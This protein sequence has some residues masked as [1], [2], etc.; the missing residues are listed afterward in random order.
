MAN[1][2][3]VCD[4]NFR[5][6]EIK[7]VYRMPIDQ[8]ASS[9]VPDRI[10]IKEKLTRQL[11]RSVMAQFSSLPE[12]LL[13][14]VDNAF[15][16]F[17]GIHGGEHL[18]IDIIITKDVVIVENTGGKGM[19]AKQLDDWL[20]WGAPIKTDSIGEYGQGGKAAMGYLGSAW[21]VHA[22]RWDES[23][24]W[25]VKDNKWDDMSIKEKTYVANPTSETRYPGLGYCK[26]EIRKL[27]KHRQD[28]ARIKAVLSNIYRK[29]LEGDRVTMTFNGDPLSLLKL[30]LY[31]G[32][33]I[34]QFKE[35]TILGFYI[36]GWVGRLKRDARV[37]NES[38]ITGGMRVLR[39]ERLICDGEYFGHPDF[40]YKASLGTLIG[41]VEL[42][43]KVPVLPNKTGFDTDSQEWLA[44]RKILYKVLEPHIK[45][46]LS[47]R[48]EETVTREERKRIS[49]IREMLIDALKLLD[50]FQ[51][52]NKL[53]EEKGR[54]S[55][56][57][58]LEE[59]ETRNEKEKKDETTPKEPRTTPPKSA[60][61]TLRRLGRMPEWELRFL[62]P[63]IRSDW[64]EK[65]GHPCLLINKNFC[66]YKERKGD[67]LYI[68]ETAIL[69]LA[70]LAGDEKLSV[71][72]YLSEANML[73][74][75]FC[76][77]YDS[78]SN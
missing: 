14:L 26:F 5:I 75:A 2:G 56:E 45:E 47:Q 22:K 52:S 64:G 18:N 73:M 54:K 62:E 57:P 1:R 49:T 20:N 4:A 65:G 11:L 40:R 13:E 25:E 15:D 9:S 78:A 59:A 77:V 48:E 32:F 38:K 37:K 21:V 29:F 70:K 39:K 66:Q 12:A 46:L 33:Q 58:K 43:A 51:I 28:I 23:I 55:P 74:R 34:Q 50:K 69:E 41:E 68:A 42:P 7:E 60:V 36:S 61:G 8:I 35:K 19:G 30:P 10:L 63:D 53:N 76:E 16:E 71:K 27:K 24:M 6:P 31:D 17:D 3:E 67:E 44:I 72:E